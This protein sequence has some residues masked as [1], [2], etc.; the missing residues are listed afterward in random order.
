MLVSRILLQ[1]PKDGEP[2]RLERNCE[3]QI[4]IKSGEFL[5]GNAALEELTDGWSKWVLD[6][7]TL[8][9][10]SAQMDRL[11]IPKVLWQKVSVSPSTTRYAIIIILIIISLLYEATRKGRGFKKPNGTPIQHNAQI[12][13][14]L[15]A[16][17]KQ[18]RFL[19]LKRRLTS[20][21]HHKILMEAMHQQWRL[22]ELQKL[23][24][25]TWVWQVE[26]SPWQPSDPGSP[27][28]FTS[29]PHWWR[30][31]PHIKCPLCLHCEG[32]GPQY[33]VDWAGYVLE[34]SCPVSICLILN[35]APIVDLW[36]QH[37]DPD[38]PTDV[39]TQSRVGLPS[40]PSPLERNGSMG[41]V[42]DEGWEQ[43]VFH[44]KHFVCH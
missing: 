17:M 1:T 36:Q 10:W 25:L 7:W 12:M 19:K 14:S 20:Q 35:V 31:C 13:E 21:L 6:I 34:K 32:T 5:L 3:T 22:Q 40:F 18:M 24:G 37:P 11:L 9:P 43:A 41:G 26:T 33:L 4:E 38:E 42:N 39:L 29:L 2:R 44:Q 23:F 28:P 16:M 30:F 8:Q 15:Q 27:T